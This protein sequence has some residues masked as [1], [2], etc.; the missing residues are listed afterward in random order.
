MVNSSLTAG[1][2]VVP[3]TAPRSSLNTSA[4]SGHEG[5]GRVERPATRLPSTGW[6]MPVNVSLSLAR[7]EG[8]WC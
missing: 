3:L 8:G 5:L 4:L 7:P 1:G 2:A 6:L